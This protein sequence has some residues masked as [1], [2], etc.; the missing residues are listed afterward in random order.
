MSERPVFDPETALGWSDIALDGLSCFLRCVE[1]VLQHRGY[2][3]TDVAQALALP[4]DLLRRRRTDFELDQCKIRWSKT[5]DGRRH[6]PVVRDLL[7]SGELVVLMPDRFY[8]PGDEFEG[9]RHF[10]DHM[11]LLYA[12]RE[13]VLSL[14]DTDAPADQGFTRA[15]EVDGTASRAFTRFA[16]VESVSPPGPEPAER[17]AAR[18]LRPSQRSLREDLPHLESFARSWREHDMNDVT[19]R[20]L[21]VAV[22][23]NVQPQLFALAETID[24][25]GFGEFDALQ[26]QLRRSAARAKQTGLLLLALHRNHTAEDEVLVREIFED[27]LN[28]LS[29]LTDSFIAALGAEVDG[30]R[31]PRDDDV[32]SAFHERLL[33][34]A[35]SCFDPEAVPEGPLDVLHGASV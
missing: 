20:A 11:V 1:S 22:L 12:V 6:W 29:T 18:V 28:E 32:P 7:E 13:N 25:L 27:L 19:A 2:S 35:R 24:R 10:H 26:G 33:S 34:I 23:A 5:K 9:R 17:F 30:E 31:H 21:H 16:V 8:W 14:L 4:L 15:V 3:P